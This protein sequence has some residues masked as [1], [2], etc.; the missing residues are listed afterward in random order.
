MANATEST[1][2]KTVYDFTIE[3]SIESPA[4]RM[5]AKMLTEKIL[6]QVIPLVARDVHN[7]F[8]GLE[9]ALNE[10]EKETAETSQN[11]G[12]A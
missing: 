2:R 3:T 9:A 1:G 12:E 5:V 7:C 11:G 8:E 10:T 4:L 6:M